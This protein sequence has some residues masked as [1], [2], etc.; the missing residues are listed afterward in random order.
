MSENIRISLLYPGGES[1]TSNVA[2]DMSCIADLDGELLMDTMKHAVAY[3]PGHKHPS[4]YFTDRIEV[5]QYRLDV[6][7]DLLNDD[8]LVSMLH[9]LLPRLEHLKELRIAGEYDP[10]DTAAS[11]YS[12]AEIELYIG[13]ID[14]LHGYFAKANDSF[15]STGF[16][17]FSSA[18]TN[19]HASASYQ[20]LKE[21]VG[22]VTYSVRNIKS[23]TIG[24]NLD[25]QLRPVEAGLV[26]IHTTPYRSGNIIDKMLRADFDDSFTCLAPLEVMGK[27]MR[28]E[29][30][31]SFRF[32][33]NRVLD[34]VLKSSV[35][36]WKP[37]VRQFTKHQT[38][39][40]VELIDEIRF[41]LGG[42]ALIHKIKATGLH[43]CKPAAVEAEQR[44]FAAYGMYHPG[45]ALRS[46]S[47]DSSRAASLVL[48]D[49]EFDRSG[50]IY[51]LT[52]PNQGGKTVFTQTAGLVQWMFQLGLFVPAY[53]AALSPVDRIFT[54]FQQHGNETDAK[55]R[56]GE[57]CFR[58]KK[59]FEKLSRY[60]LVLMDET[61]SSTSASEGTFIAGEVVMGLRAAGC[62]TIF[63]TH[64]HDLALQVEELNRSSS[65]ED[66]QIDHLTAVLDETAPGRRSY[67]IVRTRPQGLSYAKDIAEKYGI[68]FAGLVDTLNNRHKAK[69]NEA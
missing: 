55:G 69:S 38:K 30:L 17:E 47:A 32:T 58:V 54:L 63:A 3:K 45:I 14:M 48:N 15:S 9:E 27:G 4:V 46:G 41:L 13:C 61:F 40:L 2:G 20:K 10:A 50:M 11:L 65:G 18:I 56:F 21:G 51:I 66:S 53:S 52:G 6:F 36:E 12:I 19:V 35:K 49:L 5:I 44:S 42:V 68:T 64:L 67:R 33:V 57:E 28:E 8:S 22:K 23:V 16:K 37:V 1:E 62:R 26:A 31:A 43:V 39:F 7:D 25:A 59:M 24:I 29:Q 34:H 60:S